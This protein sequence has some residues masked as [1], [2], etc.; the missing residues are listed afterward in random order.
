MLFRSTHP[1]NKISYNVCNE[2]EI[3][4]TSCRLL[5]STVQSIKGC[6][7]VKIYPVA[8]SEGYS[9]VSYAGS[10]FQWPLSLGSPGSR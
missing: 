1:L 4:G 10:S 5:H 8:A 7:C 9:S 2:N 3:A 6:V